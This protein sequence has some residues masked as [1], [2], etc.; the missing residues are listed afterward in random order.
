[1]FVGSLVLKL[2]VVFQIMSSQLSIQVLSKATAGSEEFTFFEAD[3]WSPDTE[4]QVITKIQDMLGV[5]RHCGKS[6]QVKITMDVDDPAEAVFQIRKKLTNRI[7]INNQ[8]LSIREI[9]VLRLIMQG[10]TNNEIAEKLF[11]C[12]ETIKSHRKHILLKTGAKNT[13]ALI[14]H[15]HQTFFEK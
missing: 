7:E 5:V 14:S 11:V 9:E 4:R 8:K 6:F 1:M 15:Y 12:Y 3:E 2:D 10:Y 13:A